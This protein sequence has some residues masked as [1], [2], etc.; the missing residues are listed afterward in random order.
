MA[1][2]IRDIL[3]IYYLHI[4]SKHSALLYLFSWFYELHDSREKR[5]M[6]SLKAIIVFSRTIFLITVGILPFGLAAEKPKMA[7]QVLVPHKIDSKA[8]LSA[9]VHL[10]YSL[11]SRRQK[12][13]LF[14][15]FHA[16][17]TSTPNEILDI[18]RKDIVPKH[19]NT[20]VYIRREDDS[21]ETSASDYISNIAAQLGYPVIAWDP[22]YVGTLEVR[23]F[24]I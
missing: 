15:N 18:F 21:T 2:A 24:C 11:N 10:E 12:W 1:H 3:F 9:I 16:I 6:I 14:V 13:Q 23:I 5:V 22:Y 17:N 7:I 8:L 4:K 19:V 20:I